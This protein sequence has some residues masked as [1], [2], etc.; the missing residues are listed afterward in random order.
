M[1]KFYLG[2]KA[3]VA[4]NQKLKWEPEGF[5]IDDEMFTRPPRKILR[6][7]KSRSCTIDESKSIDNQKHLKSPIEVRSHGAESFKEADSDMTSMYSNA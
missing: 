7:G 1:S 4:I 3:A 2:S 5:R 6:S